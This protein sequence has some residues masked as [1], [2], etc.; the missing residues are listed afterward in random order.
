MI[1]VIMMDPALR[2]I[3]TMSP[4]LRKELTGKSQVNEGRSKHEAGH[5]THMGGVYGAAHPLETGEGL[6]LVCCGSNTN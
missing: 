6:C 4:A 2:K 1:L 3:T 5:S